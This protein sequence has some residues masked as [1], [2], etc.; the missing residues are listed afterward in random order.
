MGTYC[1]I[2]ISSG[3]AWSFLESSGGKDIEIFIRR[4]SLIEKL[5]FLATVASSSRTRLE[6][7]GHGL[8]RWLVRFSTRSMGLEI[9]RF[10][11]EIIITRTLGFN[12]FR[13]S[14]GAGNWRAAPKLEGYSNP[15]LARSRAQLLKFSAVSAEGRL[16]KACSQP[17]KQNF[18]KFSPKIPLSNFNKISIGGD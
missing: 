13:R 2:R 3:S 1:S 7:L 6:A 11:V 18:K 15:I 10:L 12:A 9:F 5:T 17:S 16:F 4:K 14:G 8:S